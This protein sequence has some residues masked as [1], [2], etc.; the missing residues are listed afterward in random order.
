MEEN[1]DKKI[2]TCEK[3]GAKQ[4]QKF[5]FKLEEIKWNFL[6][7]RKG[8]IKF[9]DKII[10]RKKNKLLKKAEKEKSK[11]KDPEIIADIDKRIDDIKSVATIQ[12]AFL[13]KEKNNSEN[14]NYHLNPKRP[15][16]FFAYLNWNKKVHEEG[17]KTNAVLLPSFAVGLV[18][19][20][21]FIDPGTTLN[22]CNGLLNAG[23]VIEGF[24]TFMNLEC[25]NVQNYNIYR[26]KKIEDKLLKKEQKVEEQ[27][28]K[29]YGKAYEVIEK[30]IDEKEDLPSID[31]II[32]NTNDIETLKVMLER[33]KQE[34]QVRETKSINKVKIKG[35]K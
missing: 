26:L 10:T 1:Y 5:F 19:A 34:Q 22:V 35:G 15:S 30:V 17:L 31:E 27:E 25:I 4:F 18:A 32:N 7:E 6:S 9:G 16:E 11:E 23:L 12:K 13:R 2:K 24:S 29:K 14:I 20:N 33:I 3:L 8:Y 28:M 21:H